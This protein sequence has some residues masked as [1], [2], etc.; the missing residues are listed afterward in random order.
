MTSIDYNK[1]PFMKKLSDIIDKNITIYDMLSENSTPLKDAKDRINKILKDEDIQDFRT[2]SF[3]YLVFYS[4]L[5]ILSILGDK[6][7]IGK[8]VRKEA[9][10]FSEEISKEP[11]DVFDTILNFLKIN[12][13]KKEI[14]YHIQK[15][16]KISLCYRIHFIDYLKA[17][18]NFK[19][20]QYMSLSMQI[21]D[22]GYVYLNKNTLKLLIREQIY[23]YITN[24]IRPISLSEIPESIKDLIFLKRKTTPPCIEAIMHKQNKSIEELKIISTYMI[25]I[26][27]S[28]DSISTFLKNNGIAT[29]EDIINKLSGNRKS[30]Y[31]V[32]SCDIMKKMNLCVS[33]CGVKNPL[34]LYFGKLD[35]TK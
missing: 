34:E 21:L 5:I 29:P 6:K 25:D 9:K 28:T 32:Y 19:D 3:P 33:N 16:R 27:A 31:I 18:K 35:I 20:N 13:E 4:E 10:L 15:G 17:T 30:K 22:K 26:G 24:L 2:Y 11:D 1:Y 8:V 7:I 14:S 12:V 23:E